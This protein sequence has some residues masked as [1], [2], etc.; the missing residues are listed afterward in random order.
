MIRYSSQKAQ[1]KKEIF[2]PFV[3]FSDLRGK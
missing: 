3:I 2:F 1:N